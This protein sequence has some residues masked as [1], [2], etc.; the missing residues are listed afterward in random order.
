MPAVRRRAPTA[1][2][3]RAPAPSYLDVDERGRITIPR[4]DIAPGERAESCALDLIEQ[5]PDKLEPADVAAVLGLSR[6]VLARIEEKGRLAIARDAELADA[7]DRAP[8]AANDAAPTATKRERPSPAS[9]DVKRRLTMALRERA[10]LDLLPE[11]PK[12]VSEL[13]VALSRT[14]TPI[15]EWWVRHVCRLLRGRELIR[16]ES[17]AVA[18]QNAP[19]LRWWPS[20]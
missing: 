19:V 9:G 10:V 11:G 6:E 16:A 2:T 13:V 18:G 5:N 14:D 12:T 7:H 15:G 20:E 1:P 17:F 8:A 4:P 3:C